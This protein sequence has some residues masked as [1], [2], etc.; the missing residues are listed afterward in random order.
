M[1]TKAEGEKGDLHDVEIVDLLLANSN[2][3]MAV[4]DKHTQI[5]CV[6]L[7]RGKRLEMKGVQHSQRVQQS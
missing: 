2:Q 4:V 7:C 5:A 1:V 3:E 6:L